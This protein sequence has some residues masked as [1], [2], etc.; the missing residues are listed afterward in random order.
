MYRIGEVDGAEDEISETL[1]ELHYLTFLD[2]A[3]ISRF[4]FG[5][6]GG[7]HIANIFRSVWP[8]WSPRR[9]QRTPDISAGS[10]C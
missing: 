4:C 9:T 5:G 6:I 7:R 2:R 1:T 10:E 8:E 3:P